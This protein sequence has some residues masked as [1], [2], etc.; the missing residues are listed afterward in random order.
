MKI[1]EHFSC[2]ATCTEIAVASMRNVCGRKSNHWTIKYFI[3]ALFPVLKKYFSIS[4][5]LIAFGFLLSHELVPHHHHEEAELTSHQ[6]KHGHD[7][8]EG[9]HSHNFFDFLFSLFHHADIEDVVFTNHS[10]NNNLVKANLSLS[11]L[12][13]ACL[14]KTYEE[15]SLRHKEHDCYYQPER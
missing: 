9:D 14:L 13:L 6:H 12:P 2:L 11:I 8:D 10:F 5:V 15:P 4:L 3:V 1:R 7:H